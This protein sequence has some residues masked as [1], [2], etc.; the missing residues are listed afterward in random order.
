MN[1]GWMCSCYG[2]NSQSP[3]LSWLSVRH[4]VAPW[5]R[6]FR[7]LPRPIEYLNHFSDTPIRYYGV[8]RSPILSPR[9]RWTERRQPMIGWVRR[10]SQTEQARPYWCIEG[11]KHIY[12]FQA[13][14]IKGVSSTRL[15]HSWSQHPCIA[16]LVLSTALFADMLVLALEGFWLACMLLYSIYHQGPHCKNPTWS[17]PLLSQGLQH[18]WG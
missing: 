13:L 11:I 17:S 6:P 5:S 1:S 12:L 14:H 18:Q 2:W 10:G 15:K 7:G 9:T 3:Y 4:W 16:Y 8:S